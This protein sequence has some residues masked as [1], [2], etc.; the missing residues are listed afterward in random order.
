MG[1]VLSLGQA[2]VDA[3]ARQD[4]GVLTGNPAKLGI[5]SI[6]IAFDLAF[7]WQHYVLFGGGG[8]AAQ[9]LPP[10]VGGARVA[11]PAPVRVSVRAQSAR[12]R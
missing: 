8:A 10:P 9:P 6:S 1:G 3:C 2:G 12:Q 4:L 11:K 7:V 5:A